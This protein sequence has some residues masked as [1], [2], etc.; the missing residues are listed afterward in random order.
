MNWYEAIFF[1]QSV[2][3][4]LKKPVDGML[5]ERIENCASKLS[6]LRSTTTMQVRI[7]DRA[8][9]KKV[10]KGPFMVE[11]PSY[12]VVLTKVGERFGLLE[13]GV[14]AERLVLYMTTKGLGTCYQGGIKLKAE[15]IPEGMCCAIVIAFGYA[16][17]ELTRD[18]KK[19]K[20]KPLSKLC[21]FAEEPDLAIRDMLK[22]A[23]MAPSAINRQPWH[24]HV[25]KDRIDLYIHADNPFEK[26]TAN[27]YLIDMGIALCHI[28]QS[29]D[30]QWKSIE[31]VRDAE[32]AEQVKDKHTLAKE[33]YVISVKI[34]A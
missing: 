11:A 28:M 20:R 5:I 25:W 12:L 3:R 21:Y 18:A 19:A 24:F 26:A 10:F 1:R 13:A 7:V 23:R 14:F 34:K 31:V 29:A 30:E 9:A 32:L 6:Y 4:F 27:S 8:E 22:S 16:E 15:E 33:L 2:R 17:R